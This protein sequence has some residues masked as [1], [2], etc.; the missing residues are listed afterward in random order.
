MT[1]MIIFFDISAFD[2]MMGLKGLI[3]VP[4]ATKIKDDC[5]FN[6]III[7][8]KKPLKNCQLSRYNVRNEDKCIR[9]ITDKLF[10]G[11]WGVGVCWVYK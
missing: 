10:R 1:G 7:K 11:D 8:R 4:Q 6:I 2:I 3:D 9:D 5:C